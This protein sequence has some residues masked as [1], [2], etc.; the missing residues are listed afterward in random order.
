VPFDFFFQKSN[1][2]KIAKENY[3]ISEAQRNEMYRRLK[4]E[5][6]SAYENYLMYKALL[7]LQIRVTQDDYT[8]YISKEKDYQDGIILQEDY[9]KAYKAW[10]DQ[11]TKRLEAQKNYNVAK[12]QLEEIIGVPIENV[13]GTNK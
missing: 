5:V 11:Q 2:I 8:L 13:V 6:L 12:I 1:N 10:A 3:L 4:A 9:N 7:D